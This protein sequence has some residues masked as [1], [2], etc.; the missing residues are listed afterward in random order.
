M[1]NSFC[2]KACLR[3]RSAAVENPAH[4][5]PCA[6]GQAR[7]PLGARN[8]CACMLRSHLELGIVARAVCIQQH[9][10][11]SHRLSM[12]THSARNHCSDVVRSR[13]VFEIVARRTSPK[14]YFLAHSVRHHARAC[15]AAT[16]RVCLKPFSV[17]N[18]HS[19]K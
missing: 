19:S 13:L 8:H 18:R 2:Q 17:R 15:S 4:G 7:Q 5:V 14:R 6:L 1:Q 10:K 12:F 16:A 11:T 3:K 9:S